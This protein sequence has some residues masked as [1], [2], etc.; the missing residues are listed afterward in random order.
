[1]FDHLPPSAIIVLAGV[2]GSGKSTWARRWLPTTAILS[3]DAMRGI[4]TDDESHLE[5]SRDA[6]A[7]LEEL[8]RLRLKYGR[9]AVIDAT[10]LRRESRQ[11]W[12]K[13][14]REH[15]VPALLVY[16][17]IPTELCIA[18]QALRTRKVPADAIRRQQTRMDDL[19]LEAPDEPWDAI[20]RVHLG[21]GERAEDDPGFEVIRSWRRKR[22]MSLGPSGVRVNHDR[23]D[24][25]GDIHG[26]SAEL[27]AL[28]ARLGWSCQDGRWSHPDDRL[29]I[30]VGD[31]ADRGPDSVGV[32]ERVASLV[33]Q[34]KALLVL[35]NHD[36]KL[37]RWLQGRNVKLQHG[38][39][40]TAA[41]FEAL[42]PLQRTTLTHR[43]IDLLEHAPLWALCD[44]EPRSQRPIPERIAVAHACWKPSLLGASPQK[45]RSLCIYGPTTGRTVD[46]LPERLDW[47]LDHPRDAPLVVHGHTAYNGPVR[48]HNN[49]LCLDTG[50]AFGGHLTAFRWPERELIQEPA[51]QRWSPRDKPLPTEPGLLMPE[52]LDNQDAPAAPAKPAAPAV[53]ESWGIGPKVAFDL[54]VDR[55][56]AT[57]YGNPAA[58]LQDVDADPLLLRKAPEGFGDA[59][60]RLANAGK[61]LFSPQAEHQL[62][63]KGLVY[64]RDPWRPLS[65][66]Y[67]KMYNYGERDDVRDLAI[68]LAQSDGVEVIFNEKLDGTLIQSFSTARLGLGP[69]RVVLTTR[70]MIEGAD[71][72]SDDPAE[73]NSSGFNYLAAAR[74]LLRRDTPAALDPQRHQGLTL[75]W[76]L[77]HPGSR[78]VTDYG[79]REELA[80]TGAVDARS[81]PP[82]YL[83]RH[84]LEALAVDLGAP[85]TPRLALAGDTLDAR[86]H[87]LQDYLAGTDREGAVLTFEGTDA[88]GRPAVLHRVK[89]KGADYIRTLRQLAFCTWDR[90]RSLLEGHPHIQT[91]D[92]FRDLLTSL[93]SD[94]VPEEVLGAWRVHWDTW[95]AYHRDLQT[96]I[97]RTTALWD[98]YGQRHPA[99]SRADDP[100]AYGLWRRDLA[101]FARQ[102]AG[103]VDWLL[104]AAA[105]D[106]ITFANLHSRLRAN[107][108][109]VK[110]LSDALSEAAPRLHTLLTEPKP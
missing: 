88:F 75:L 94:L 43:V 9:I 12:L 22:V 61:Q 5:C 47:T 11:P 79:D 30:F 40:T 77:I 91:W 44:P 67:L 71:A 60:V 35:G 97:D 21:L 103:A 15:R 13:I 39:E 84:E 17:D 14:A 69:E 76:E 107:A 23:L 72:H 7:M 89:V 34:E 31:L 50:C 19:P 74:A 100:R 85:I 110:A 98:A 18:R 54:R 106:K 87:A 82:R 90:A 105:D 42:P 101:A 27:D 10:N 56:L 63:A 20:A 108:E 102:H 81:A 86:L 36:D 70:G 68:Q 51:R 73:D 53:P 58:I 52:D 33:E 45:T 24:L 46:G 28:L 26:C 48:E 93:G 104:F 96:V 66:P 109:R 37:L 16:F 83:P 57:L 49:T 80:L 92:A 3:S 25:I 59:Q 41:E 55:L 6:F 38:M 32:L 78:I 95:D 8:A 29:L 4:L 65:V 2:A 64:Q 1:M 99:P 62:Y